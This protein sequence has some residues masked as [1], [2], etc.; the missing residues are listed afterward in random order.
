MPDF[1]AGAE[2]DAVMAGMMDDGKYY[3]TYYQYPSK[4]EPGMYETY[5]CTTQFKI[6]QEYA[7]TFAVNNYEGP[8]EFK[9]VPKRSGTWNTYM[10]DQKTSNNLD[11][12]G[13]EA[14][15]SDSRTNVMSYD[16]E[17]RSGAR[18]CTAYRAI[19]AVGTELDR[20]E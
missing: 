14:P 19:A 3:Q 10:E 17:Y 7:T 1:M 18:A 4:T 8:T 15:S 13:W 9:V 20:V 16:P 2:R 12:A 11:Y 6:D 5:T